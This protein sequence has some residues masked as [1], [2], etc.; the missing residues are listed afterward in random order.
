MDN[1]YRQFWM[2][3]GYWLIDVVAFHAGG[4]YMLQNR[5]GMMH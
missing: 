2:P 1:L 3:G 4:A 5:L